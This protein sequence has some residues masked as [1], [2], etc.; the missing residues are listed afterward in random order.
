MLTN[1]E[2]VRERDIGA[3]WLTL[4]KYKDD[5][6]VVFFGVAVDCIVQFNGSL[7]ECEGAWRKWVRSLNAT[8]REEGGEK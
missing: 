4:S 6:G 8:K 7:A 3:H 5:C 1:L 2:I